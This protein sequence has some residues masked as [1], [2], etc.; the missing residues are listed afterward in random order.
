M[1]TIFNRKRNE[2][3]EK[4]GGKRRIDSSSVSVEILQ[5]L[6]HTTYRAHTY[7]RI[8]V[9]S[10][11]DGEKNLK[12]FLLLLLLGEENQFVAH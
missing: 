4:S 10:R 6:T 5:S 2:N 11:D 3:N 12:Q 1:R 9:Q 8:D 7:S